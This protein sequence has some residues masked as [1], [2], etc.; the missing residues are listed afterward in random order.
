MYR[1]PTTVGEVPPA[2][3]TVTSTGPEAPAGAVAVT[4][5]ADTAVTLVAATVPNVTPVAPVRLVP[6]MV[7]WVPPV[8][9]PV[10]GLIEVTAGGVT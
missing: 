5:V 2:V 6:V 8:V 7:T 4:S 1:S 9:G 3:V 10:V